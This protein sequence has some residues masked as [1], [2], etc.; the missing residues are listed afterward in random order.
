MSHLVAKAEHDHAYE[1]GDNYD[2]QVVVYTEGLDE[3]AGD[4]IEDEICEV[5]EYVSSARR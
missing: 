4:D 3:V 1:D 2:L 5:A